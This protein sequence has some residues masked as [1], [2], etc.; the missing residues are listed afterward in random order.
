MVRKLLL[1][2]LLPAGFLIVACGGGD[3]GSTPTSTTLTGQFLDAPVEGLSY[4]TSSGLSGKTDA[5]GTFKYRKN[6][7]VTFK[8]ND[9]IVLGSVTG[10]SIVTPLDL[11]G[12]N[13]VTDQKVT[14]IVAFMLYLDDD[15]D[16]NNGIRIDPN[17]IPSVSS[18]VDLSQTTTP[19]AEIQNAINTVGSA[20]AQNHMTATIAQIMNDHIAGNY[21]GTFTRTSGDPS[22]A[23]G[24]TVDVTVLNTGSVSGTARTNTGDTYSVSGNID[25]RS[26]DA[27]GTGGG[28]TISWQGEWR[29][30]TISGTWTFSGAITCS[31]TFSVS[32]Q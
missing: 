15:G 19:P 13:S 20:T 14:N 22:C 3:G 4:T 18:Q 1:S 17:K 8:V 21:S 12:A 25:Y 11:V 2:A 5:Q 29:N 32:K 23:S 27:S 28:G 9:N 30:N 24:G 26:F 6:D 10:S 16:P 7:K 31:G